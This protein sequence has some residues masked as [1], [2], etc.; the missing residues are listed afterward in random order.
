VEGRVQKIRDN[1][2]LLN[3][4]MHLRSHVQLLLLLEQPPGCLLDLNPIVSSQG[5]IVHAGLAA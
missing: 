2:A 5:M 1:M 4:V 3:Q